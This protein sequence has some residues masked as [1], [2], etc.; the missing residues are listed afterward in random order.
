VRVGSGRRG[1]EGE[2][3][4]KESPGEGGGREKKRYGE[5]LIMPVAIIAHY[6]S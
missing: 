6:L 2:K 4:E 1:G 3:G 5:Q